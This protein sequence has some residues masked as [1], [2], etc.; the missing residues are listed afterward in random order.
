MTAKHYLLQFFKFTHLP[1][2][3]REVS[4]PFATL[5]EALDEQL[6]DNPEKS[7][8]MR[9]L[10]EAKDCAVRAH[11]YNKEAEIDPA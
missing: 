11:V 7:A 6:P 4:R 5:A 10:L 9:K 8:A 1:P 2:T 3:L